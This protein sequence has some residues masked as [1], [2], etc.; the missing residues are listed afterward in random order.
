MGVGFK[1]LPTAQTS[2]CHLLPIFERIMAD[3]ILNLSLDDIIANKSKKPSGLKSDK[4]GTRTIGK[5]VRLSATGNVRCNTL[6]LPIF[7]GC[8]FVKS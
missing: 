5:K 6:S 4:P 1:G 2:P 7:A 8:S 3:D